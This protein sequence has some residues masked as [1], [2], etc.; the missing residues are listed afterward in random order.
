MIYIDLNEDI[1]QIHCIWELTGHGKDFG[2]III[3]MKMFKDRKE[4]ND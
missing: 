1:S 3:T 4:Q 2:L